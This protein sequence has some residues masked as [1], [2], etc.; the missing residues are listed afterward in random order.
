MT[1]DLTFVLREHLRNLFFRLKG[2]KKKIHTHIK[3]SADYANEHNGEHNKI[4]QLVELKYLLQWNR[5]KQITLQKKKQDKNG[6]NC[7]FS[8][9]KANKKPFK[10]V[11]SE[12]IRHKKCGFE[13]QEKQ[14][15]I[16]D[17]MKPTCV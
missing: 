17:R 8:F 14:T 7:Y 12:C 2:T 5:E 6:K 11:S 10:S 16:F 13:K 1:S 15:K 3:H 9:Q 4:L